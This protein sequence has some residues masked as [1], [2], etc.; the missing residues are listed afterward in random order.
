MFTRPNGALLGVFIEKF[1]VFIRFLIDFTR[2]R[3]L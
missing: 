3:V 2:A 1:I